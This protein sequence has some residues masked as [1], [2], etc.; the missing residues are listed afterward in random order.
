M[1]VLVETLRE[2]EEI[3]VLTST[4]VSIEERRRLHE[5]LRSTETEVDSSDELTLVAE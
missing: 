5:L 4:A 1:E 2:L 3:A